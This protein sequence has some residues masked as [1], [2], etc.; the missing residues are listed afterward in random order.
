MMTCKNKLKTFIENGVEQLYNPK[1]VSV[2]FSSKNVKHSEFLLTF[3]C[4]SAL[5]VCYDR[6]LFLY[7]SFNFSCELQATK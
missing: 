5:F 6:T 1:D 3:V 4:R 7:I 2:D